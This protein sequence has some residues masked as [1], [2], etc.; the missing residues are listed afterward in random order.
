MK[1]VI[2]GTGPAGVIAAETLRRTDPKCSVT[3]IGDEPEAPYSRMALPYLLADNIK[4]DGTHLRHGKD[5]YKSLGID[6]VQDEVTAVDGD[7]KSVTLAKGGDLKFDRLLIATGS[8]AAR[9][10]IPGMDLAGVENCWTLEDGRKIARAT[11]KGSRVVLMGAGFIGCIVLEALAARG[12]ELTVV[13]MEDRML[14]RMMDHTGGD[15]IKR[16]CEAKGVTVLTSTKV[17]G[18]E[19]AGKAMKISYAD[20][21][22][23]EVD[24]VVCA[25]G[26][27]PNIAFLDGS[28]I[29]TDLGVLV[30]NSL[31]TSK[32]GIYAAGDVAQGPELLTGEKE[33]HA[34]QPTASE[35]GR[36]AA[37]NMAGEATYYRGSLSMNVLNTLGLVSSSFGQW[38]GIEGGDETSAEDADH[39]RY[40]RLTFK[41]DVV[42]GALALGLTEHVGVI[43]GLIQTGVKLG[44]WKD[45]L[46]EDPTRVMEA[47]LAR[48]QGSSYGY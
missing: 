12:V 44:H 47:Y 19:E 43:R 35:H 6:L 10:P 20:G 29:D 14:P 32:A 42:V 8:H 45:R 39:F 4:E 31:K 11:K 48:T 3:L 21:S 2:I 26:V 5:H 13:E 30:D 7:G 38:D 15:M 1:H 9:P 37:L 46:I 18:I 17:T 41:D 34:I 22:S 24:T 27:V 33:I 40:L 28:G 23:A 16:W 36:I 25:T